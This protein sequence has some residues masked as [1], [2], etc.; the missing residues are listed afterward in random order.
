MISATKLYP[1]NYAG[2]CG[3]AVLAGLILVL[4]GTFYSTA[5]GAPKPTVLDSKRFQHPSSL[6]TSTSVFSPFLNIWPDSNGVT[7]YISAQDVGQLGGTV[8][9]N[10]DI[11]P[12]H[13]KGGYAM[14]YSSTNQI[15]LAAAPHFTANQDEG[16]TLSITTTLGLNSGTIQ[17]ERAF[18]QSNVITE[19]VSVDNDAFTITMPNLGTLPVD[20]YVAVMSTLALPGPL[21]P[22]YHLISP[23]YNMRA[24]GSLTQSDKLMTLELHY[25]EPLPQNYDPHTLAVLSWNFYTWVNLGGNL[26]DDSNYLSFSTKEF[27]LY[28]LAVTPTWRDSFKEFNLRGVATRSNIEWGPG[29]SLILSNGAT[30]GTVTSVSITPP[31]DA[32]EWG[33]LVFNTT[34]PPGTAIT[35]EVLD[36][37]NQIVL[38]DVS[39]GTNLAQA[40]INLA[41]YPSLKLRATLTSTV[42]G[43]TPALLEWSL[44]W[45][46]IERNVFLPVVSKE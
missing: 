23:S 6:I 21:P 13:K 43:M 9:A 42:V 28:A 1:K 36:D 41:T 8:F 32:A 34:T 5:K 15:Y 31:V 46:V 4:L 7:L 45:S 38:P 18:I 37:A 44:S 30:T 12:G 24:S 25:T 29:D 10:L 39:S 22:G 33:I 11:G 19:E 2:R 35:V 17:L 16:G 20:A 40:G 27:G 3:L 26:F 14:T